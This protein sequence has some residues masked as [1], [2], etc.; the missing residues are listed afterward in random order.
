MN[1]GRSIRMDRVLLSLGRERNKYNIEKEYE[2]K[3]MVHGVGVVVYLHGFA[4]SATG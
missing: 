4:G 3:C 1:V 2:E